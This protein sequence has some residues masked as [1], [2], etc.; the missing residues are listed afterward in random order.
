MAI[1][2][3]PVRPITDEELLQLAR[4]NPGYQFERG[5]NGELIVT[6]TGSEGGRRSME[7]GYQLT[8]WNRGRST[9]VTFDSSTGFRLPDGSVLAPDASWVWLERW[10][11]L[12]PG[13]RK[14]FAPLCPDAVF[15]IRSESDRRVDLRMKM[16]AYLKNGARLAVLIDPNRRTVEIH[17]PAAAPQIL[18]EVTA[19]QL[20]PEL[21]GFVLDL[22]AIFS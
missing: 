12:T 13:E 7:L 6:P 2:L 8:A 21:A 1:S 18:E 3:T 5:A 11:M 10:E 22:T 16:I 9:G 15:E 20:D 19:V 14:G 4:R 17:R